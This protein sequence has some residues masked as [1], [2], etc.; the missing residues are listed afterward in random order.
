MMTA[1]RAMVIGLVERMRRP[2][3]LGTLSGASGSDAT[4]QTED[5]DEKLPAR[6]VQH[7]GFA[8][9]PPDGTSG[10]AVFQGGRSSGALVVATDA[11]GAPELEEGE[12]VL[13]A[14]NGARVLV[15]KDGDLVLTP[16]AG[17][18][19]LLGGSSAEQNV[20]LGTDLLA[21]LQAHVVALNA[22]THSLG[23]WPTTPPTP[24]IEPPTEVLLSSVVEVL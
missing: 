12:S 9:R 17:R 1:I 18:K 3:S 11:A 5:E 19:V 16:A 13:Y 23:G 6:L 14:S 8:S 7:Y 21:W 22:H 15:T 2:A 24:P 10:V 20:V 4:L